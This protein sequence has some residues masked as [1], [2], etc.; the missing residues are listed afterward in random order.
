M[1]D[2]NAEARKRFTA[3]EGEDFTFAPASLAEAAPLGRR[4]AE[5]MASVSP[6]VEFNQYH[7]DKGRF[8]SGSSVGGPVTTTTGPLP[9]DI[10]MDK[11]E[12]KIAGQL[13]GETLAA[14]GPDGKLVF[15]KRETGDPDGPD[16]PA[17]AGVDLTDAEMAMVKGAVITHNHP[18]WTDGGKRYY[19]SLS[20][21]DVGMTVHNG[22]A[23]IRA[24]TPD[25]RLYSLKPG[26]KGWGDERVIGPVVNRAVREVEDDFYSKIYSGAPGW[27]NTEKGRQTY[28]SAHHWDAVW[29]KVAPR[30][31]WTY[32]AGVFR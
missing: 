4:E 25:G 30:L 16:G 8:A 9:A 1:T 32:T 28:A 13:D 26:P 6:L 20:I 24:V 19:D 14:F 5:G 27:P 3:V 12:E 31:G 23:E 22:G 15:S 10:T 21:A 11:A 17:V 18:G 2:F 29:Q 7:D